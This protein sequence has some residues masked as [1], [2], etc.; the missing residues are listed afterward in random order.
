MRT[1][2]DRACRKMDIPYYS[3]YSTGRRDR[4]ELARV[5]EDRRDPLT[6]AL[7]DGRISFSTRNGRLILPDQADH[8]L[9]TLN[10]CNSSSST[11]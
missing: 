2:I 3:Q 1:K 4:D 7:D 10:N 8:L 5:A 9:R 6:R 11:G